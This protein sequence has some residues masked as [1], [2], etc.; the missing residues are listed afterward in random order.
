MIKNEHLSSA[1]DF[2]KLFVPLLKSSPQPSSA[3]PAIQPYD[4]AQVQKVQAEEIYCLNTP[5]MR[6]IKVNQNMRER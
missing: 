4:Y 2:D 6:A 1:A 3:H 5:S